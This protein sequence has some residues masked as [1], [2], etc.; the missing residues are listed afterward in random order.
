MIVV[1]EN[2]KVDSS[3]FN[4]QVLLGTRPIGAFICA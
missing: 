2:V 1:L 3:E 4:E